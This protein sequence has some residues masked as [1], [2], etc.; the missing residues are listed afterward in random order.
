MRG[1]PTLLAAMT[2]ISVVSGHAQ[3]G[4]CPGIPPGQFASQ[5][6]VAGNVTARAGLGLAHVF[7]MGNISCSEPYGLTR[8]EE[9][10]ARAVHRELWFTTPEMPGTLTPPAPNWAF[11]LTNPDA[12]SAGVRLLLKPASIY[13]ALRR[14]IQSFSLRGS[15]K[16]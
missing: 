14:G 12:S 15:N 6:K 3:S 10:P 2:L 16:D 1:I 9:S 8:S 13:R 7:S 4:K 5:N 11:R